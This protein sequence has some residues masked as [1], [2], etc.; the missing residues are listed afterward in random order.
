MDGHAGTVD[1]ARTAIDRG[2]WQEAFDLL[3]SLGSERSLSPPELDL[4]GQAAYGAGEFEAAI[5]AWEQAHRA[6]ADSGDDVA[7]AKA[8]ATIAMYLMMDT[9]LMA[10]VRGWLARAE[11]LLVG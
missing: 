6:L 9:G 11:S 4:F 3:L 10:P 2:S 7:A 8:A 1:R 5:T